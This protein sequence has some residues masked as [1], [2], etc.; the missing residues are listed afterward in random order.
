MAAY[1]EKQKVVTASEVTEMSLTK[2]LNDLNIFFIE[3][4]HVHFMVAYSDP[5]K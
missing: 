3:H 2:K 1:I 5:V 4:W